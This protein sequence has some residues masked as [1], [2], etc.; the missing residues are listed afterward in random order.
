L[1]GPLSPNSLPP[2]HPLLGASLSS[3]STLGARHLALPA[4]NPARRLADGDGK[5]LEGA[6]GAVVVVVAAQAVD[7]EGDARGAGEALKAVGDH[8]AAEVANLLAL[9]TEV[10]DAVGTVREVDDG[11]AERLVQG[12]VCVAEPGQANRGAE[13]L[14]EGV[15]ERDADVLGGVV[16][17]DCKSTDVLDNYLRLT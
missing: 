16:V 9:E 10:D 1:L 6:L 8:L 12:S 14:G 7:V 11:P 17:V 4:G 3:Q 2:I 5:S 15:A 13:G